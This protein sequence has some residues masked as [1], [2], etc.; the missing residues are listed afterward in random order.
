MKNRLFLLITCVNFCTISAMQEDF[1]ASTPPQSPRARSYSFIE[2]EE[3]VQQNL[4]DLELCKMQLSSQ[5]NQQKIEDGKLLLKQFYFEK[6]L[7]QAI[8]K[9][10]GLAVPLQ[11]L[12][13]EELAEK[14]RIN[15]VLMAPFTQK[16]ENIIWALYDIAAKIH[17]KYFTEGTFVIE[18]KG[19]KLLN[20]LVSLENRPGGSY[21]RISTHFKAYK[22]QHY[23][24]DLENLPCNKHT[25][26]FG[27]LNQD[28][29]FIKPEN[30]GTKNIT[31][32]I[33]HGKETIIAQ[34]RK[35]EWLRELFS[36]ASDQSEEFK[37]E[38]IPSDMIKKFSDLIKKLEP[39]KE[40]QK[41]H[42]ESVKNF[43][44][45]KIVALLQEYINNFPKFQQIIHEQPATLSESWEE[46]TKQDVNVLRDLLN[47]TVDFL[48]ELATLDNIALR[49]GYE[50][51]ITQTDIK[52][53]LG[54]TTQAPEQE[55]VD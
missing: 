47:E 51:I 49:S 37:K 26:L 7:K 34:A 40:T 46:V 10:L 20:Y 24:L 42:I 30:H 15:S 29:I 23:G 14:Q 43:G 8:T 19:L 27:H 28:R 32:T 17:N 1:P 18:D 44:V 5:D 31:D 48:D 38:R 45:Q 52:R 13:P 53:A 4:N 33:E 21:T 12:T 39:D 25:I 6:P 54:L 35:I 36:L 55:E 41:L 3:A 2:Q 9:K 16:A 22:T 50:V 11:R